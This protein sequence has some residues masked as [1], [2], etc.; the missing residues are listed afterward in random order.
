MVRCVRVSRQRPARPLLALGLPL[1][2]RRRAGGNSKICFRARFA[3]SP[4]VSRMADIS[5][6]EWTD[7]TFNPWIGCQHASPGCDHCYAEQQNIFRKWAA[8]GAWGP[9][10][11]RR[12]TS[13]ANWKKPV[14]WNTDGRHFERTHGRRR[15]VFCASLADVFDNKVPVGWRTDLFRLIRDTPN[16]DWQLLTK[17]PQNIA[18][19]L[20]PDWGT[21]GYP[22]VWLGATTE[23]EK[24]YRMRWPVL[25]R[26]P[27]V[28]HFISYEPAIGSLGRSSGAKF[29]HAARRSRFGQITCVNINKT[30]TTSGTPS[31]QSMIGISA[32]RL[33]I[34]Q[35][36]LA[37]N[38]RVVA[39]FP[40][41][42]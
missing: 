14:V 42:R 23:D 9:H 26:V 11:E 17:R 20:P 22:N 2:F 31:N 28:V 30:T 36:R 3:W 7:S 33:L 32:S 12:R 40:T 10:A 16:L 19:M 5:K 6:I 24:H 13:V 39:K 25:A 41:D 4:I 34:R 29:F 27:A 18:N 8:D 15:R 1:G 37:S 21:A 35:H 38:A